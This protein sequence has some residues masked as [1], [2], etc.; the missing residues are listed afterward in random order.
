[1]IFRIILFICLIYTLI[2]FW[3]TLNKPVTLVVFKPHNNRSKPQSF[4]IFFYW[5]LRGL[6]HFIRSYWKNILLSFSYISIKGIVN[7]ILNIH[8]RFLWVWEYL[9]YNMAFYM[10]CFLLLFFFKFLNWVIK[11]IYFLIWN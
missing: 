7:G 1:M 4:I 9:M 10:G 6:K 2:I 8:S 5:K 3:N 11:A